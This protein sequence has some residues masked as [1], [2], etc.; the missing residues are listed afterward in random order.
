MSLEIFPVEGIPEITAGRDIGEIIAAWAD[1]RAGD[2]VVVAQKIVSKS[3]GRLV[4]VDPARRDTERARLVERES[5]R[6]VARRGDLMIVQT[7]HGFVCAN[8]GIDASNVPP[9]Y[10]SLLPEDC[11]ASAARIRARINDLTGLDVGVVVSDTFG[12]P[13]R[14]GLTNVALGVA[15]LSPLRDHRGETDVFGAQLH[16]TV[17]AVADEIAGAAELVMGKSDGIPVAVVRGIATLGAGGH[18]RDLIRTP[19]QDLFPLGI[20]DD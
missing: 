18:G 5:V 20:I 4:P 1:L 11:D 7:R 12:R 13:W 10:V 6:L 2:V 15:G 9:G 17:I 3:E 8:A 16:A 14:T 19:E